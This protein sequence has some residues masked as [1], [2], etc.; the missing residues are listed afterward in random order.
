M[1]EAQKPKQA[2]PRTTVL[3]LDK[4][5]SQPSGAPAAPPAG[6]DSP[7]MIIR[8]SAAHVAEEGHQPVV[9]PKGSPSALPPKDMLGA[10]SYAYAKGVY[11]SEDIERKMAQ[12]PAM[13][14]ALHDE[15]PDSHAI[16]RF[17]RLNHQAILETLEG[18][19]RWVRR[20]PA[21]APVADKPAPAPSKA[22]PE[23]GSTTIGAKRAAEARLDEAAFVD[24]MSKDD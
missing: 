16:R 4:F 11:R 23:E 6:D 1:N 13:R 21:A 10:V 8:K 19:F 14:A 24:N 3:H 20:K 15:I 7:T 2:E 17:R 5:V 9:L 12:D 22:P 18:F